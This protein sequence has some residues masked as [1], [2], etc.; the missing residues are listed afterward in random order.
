MPWQRGLFERR[1]QTAGSRNVERLRAE[2][3]LNDFLTH[4]STTTGGLAPSTAFCSH[5]CEDR[6]DNVNVFQ[7]HGRSDDEEEEE[8]SEP[9]RG[10]RSCFQL[11]C[12][13]HP[14]SPGSEPGTF[15]RS[16]TEGLY[17]YMMTT[18][19]RP[20]GLNSVS[21]LTLLK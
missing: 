15:T 10:V 19:M 6:N 7:R 5:R 14:V 1:K 16:D 13:T 20:D 21:G 18:L 3:Q 9:Q 8:E 4:F 2:C 17:S 11:V 12:Q